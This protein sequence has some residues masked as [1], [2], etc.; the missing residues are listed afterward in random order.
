VLNNLVGPYQKGRVLLV[1]R[2]EREALV[3]FEKALSIEPDFIET[4]SLIMTVYTRQKETKKAVE[5]VG[6]QIKVLTQDPF[7]YNML[8]YLYELNKNLAKTEGRYEKAIEINSN[9]AQLQIF[10]GN[11]YVRQNLAE[12]A[13]KEYMEIIETIDEALT[14][15]RIAKGQAPDASYISDTLGWAYYKKKIFG[16]A[17]V[18]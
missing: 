13:V 17:I 6:A 18:Y 4:L 5:R 3:H 10:L 14:L 9:V 2:K 8:G 16:H 11:F 1:Q 15:S 7:L 12:K